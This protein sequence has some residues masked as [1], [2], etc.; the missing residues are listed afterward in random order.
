PSPAP[1]RDRGPMRAPDTPASE[2]NEACPPFSSSWASPS[3]GF[4]P[5]L[6]EPSLCT[7]SAAC[8]ATCVVTRLGDRSGRLRVLPLEGWVGQALRTDQEW[9]IGQAQVAAGV[10]N[11]PRAHVGSEAPLP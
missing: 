4:G 10:A 1:L 7:F 5:Q 9:S 6:A 2:A 11:G 8:A 3:I